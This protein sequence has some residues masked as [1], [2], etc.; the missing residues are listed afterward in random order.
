MSPRPYLQATRLGLGLAWAK[1]RTCWLAKVG[2]RRWRSLCWPALD[3]ED[4]LLTHANM[5]KCQIAQSSSRTD[6]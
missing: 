6:F 4:N 1:I 5:G 2:C 3:L